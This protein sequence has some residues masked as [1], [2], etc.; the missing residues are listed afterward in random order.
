VVA[1]GW[2]RKSTINSSTSAFNS[3]VSG[4]N[5]TA[6][7][8]RRIHSSPAR[9]FSARW[10]TSENGSRAVV[11]HMTAEERAGLWHGFAA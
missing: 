5:A 10:E 2:F 4:S 6:P 8:R 9:I 7:A 3:A 1:A 11:L